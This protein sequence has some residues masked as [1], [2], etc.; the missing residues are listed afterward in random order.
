MSLRL[1]FEIEPSHCLTDGIR[2]RSR[3]EFG[4]MVTQEILE[5]PGGMPLR[6]AL[7]RLEDGARRS[8]ADHLLPHRAGS[9]GP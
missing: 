6:A 8:L 4:G 7:R 5:L 1:T 9:T 2:L 3:Y